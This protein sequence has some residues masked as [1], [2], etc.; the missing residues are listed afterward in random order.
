MM[1]ELY[2]SPPYFLSGMGMGVLQVGPLYD[3][4][5][6]ALQ[7]SGYCMLRCRIGGVVK[8]RR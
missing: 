2:A 3:L 7:I 1:H 6:I 5:G 8:R 4:V